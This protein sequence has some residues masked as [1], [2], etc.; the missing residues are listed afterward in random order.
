MRTFRVRIVLSE[1]TAI[2][3]RRLCTSQHSHVQPTQ[4]SGNEL[5]IKPPQD[6]PVL[7]RRKQFCSAG[8]ELFKLQGL[9]IFLLNVGIVRVVSVCSSHVGQQKGSM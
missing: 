9:F 1:L 2:M 4:N 8:L 7:F 3:G 5:K 6:P